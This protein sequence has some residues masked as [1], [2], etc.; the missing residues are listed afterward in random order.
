ML[1]WILLHNLLWSNKLYINNSHGTAAA[2]GPMPLLSDGLAC[3]GQP[4]VPEERGS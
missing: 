1:L 3:V 4:D 2:N